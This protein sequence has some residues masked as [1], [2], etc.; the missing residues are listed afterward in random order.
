MGTMQGTGVIMTIACHQ[1]SDSFRVFGWSREVSLLHLNKHPPADALVLHAPIRTQHVQL[2]NAIKR[3]ERARVGAR[4]EEGSPV[5]Q[6]RALWPCRRLHLF[7]TL[8]V[9]TQTPDAYDH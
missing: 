8:Y 2:P 6:M 9:H 3:T 4:T 5:G 7:L 1:T